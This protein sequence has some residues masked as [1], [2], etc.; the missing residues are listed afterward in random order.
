MRIAVDCSR[1]ATGSWRPSEGY[2]LVCVDEFTG[3][4]I[5]VPAVTQSAAEV[6]SKLEERVVGIF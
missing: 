3:F 2:R 4:M 1:P 6:V 5:L